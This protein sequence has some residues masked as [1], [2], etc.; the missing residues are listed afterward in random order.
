VYNKE[1][2]YSLPEDR[3]LCIKNSK[4]EIIVLVDSDIEFIDKDFFISIAKIFSNQEVSIL[5]PL[6]IG[7]NDNITQSLGLHATMGIQYIYIY[8]FNFPNMKPTEVNDI[9]KK[10]LLRIQMVHG[11]CFIFRKIIFFKIG[12]FD[13]FMEPYNFDEMDFAIRTNM[14]GYKSFATSKISI[15]H[16]SGG[17]TSNFKKLIGLNFL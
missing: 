13:E 2:Q 8:T 5:L 14:H 16:H 12:G 7:A 4:G 17:T 6:I 3:N 10:K 15:L 11:A 1:K 9:T